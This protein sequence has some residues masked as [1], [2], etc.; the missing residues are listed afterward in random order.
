MGVTKRV[1]PTKLKSGYICIS[2]AFP[3]AKEVFERYQTAQLSPF[4]SQP[5][6]SHG[7]KKPSQSTTSPCCAAKGKAMR[8]N[9]MKADKRFMPQRYEMFWNNHIVSRFFSGLKM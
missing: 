5:S 2:R 6:S 4:T 3:P 1:V 9:M 7:L 8:T